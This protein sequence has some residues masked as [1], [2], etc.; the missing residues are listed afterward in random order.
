MIVRH[1]PGTRWLPVRIDDF[2]KW[3]VSLLEESAARLGG[4]L[5]AGGRVHRWGSVGSVA[6][7]TG[8]YPAQ[9]SQQRLTPATGKDTAHNRHLHWVPAGQLCG[10]PHREDVRRASNLPVACPL[11]R[12][13]QL[14]R[15]REGVA[16]CRD[17]LA[18][19]APGGSRRAWR[20]PGHRR[21]CPLVPCSA[22]DGCRPG[23]GPGTEGLATERA[24]RAARYTGSAR[25]V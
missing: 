16:M 7:E 10:A 8:N 2:E 4:V 11:G 17:G 21:A 1:A 18:G 9:H 15:H 3:Q 19:H 6:E 23:S 22:A 14:D 20:L 13:P 24:D 25:T 12:R 5:A